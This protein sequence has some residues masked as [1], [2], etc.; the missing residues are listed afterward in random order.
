MTDDRGRANEPG[1]RLFLGIERIAAALVAVMVLAVLFQVVAR[2]AFASPPSWT[3][4][5]ARYAMI[6]GGSLGA[7][8]AFRRGFDPSLIEPGMVFRGPL[9]TAGEL[10]ALVPAAVFSAT[11]FLASL[12]GPNMDPG[13]SFMAR[14]LGRLS[15]AL[16]INMGFVAAALPVMAFLVLA[17]TAFRILLVIRVISATSRGPRPPQHAL[18]SQAAVPP[19]P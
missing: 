7:V 12:F 6:W 4:E 17:A 9:R 3:Q 18:F 1:R 5:L 13:R 10:L 15:E 8:A 14:N 2:Y 16:Q 11:L 19:H